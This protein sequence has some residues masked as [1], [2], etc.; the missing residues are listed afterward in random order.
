ML[1]EVVHMVTSGLERNNVKFINVSKAE[2]TRYLET[3]SN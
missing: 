1:Q 2:A 3:H